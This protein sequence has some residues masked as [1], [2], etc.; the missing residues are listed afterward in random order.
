MSPVKCVL[1]IEQLRFGWKPGECLLAI[2]ELSLG[3]GESLFLHGPSGSGKSS[4]LGLIGGVLTADRGSITIQNC[5]MLSLSRGQRDAFRA[6]HI[7]FIFQQFNLLPY[8]NA[9]DNVLL[10]LRFAPARRAKLG[11]VPVREQ[12]IALLTRLGLPAQSVQGRSA[13]ELSVGQQQRVAAARALIGAPAVVIADEPTSALDGDSREAFLK[14]LF[15]ECVRTGSALLFV[16]HDRS[17]ESRFD[18]VVH[19][20]TLNR[21]AS[22]EVARC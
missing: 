7:G 13:S 11:A 15:A 4:L 14:V 21:A 19:L 10:G 20:P 9:I 18:R 2:D 8:L 17:L 16:S 12:A 1:Q 3:A 5:A 6:E 22:A